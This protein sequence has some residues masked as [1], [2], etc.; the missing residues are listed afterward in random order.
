[1]VRRLAMMGMVAGM[2]LS[3]PAA[4]A[5]LVMFETK[6]CV[7]CLVWHRDIG[8]KYPLTDE[9]KAAPLR[10]VE[11]RGARPPDLAAVGAVSATPTFV[12]VHDGREIGRITGFPGEDFF[13]PML[14][15]LL[16]KVP[17]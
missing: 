8:P 4:S 7:W 11:Q 17:E 9:G 3:A 15:Q 6:G 5:E 16:A 12:L 13:W 2:L 10:V 1:M 14:A